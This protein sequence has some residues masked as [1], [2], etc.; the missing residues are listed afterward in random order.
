MGF[1]AFTRYIDIPQVV[2]YLF[3]IFFVGLIYYLRRE[4]KREGYPLESDRG[5]RVRV[6]GFPRVP[7]PKTFKLRGGGTYQAPPGNPESREIHAQAAQPWPGSPQQPSGDPMLDA[8]GP[9]SYAEREDKPDLTIDGEPMIVPLRVAAGYSVA[10]EDPDP[11]GMDVVAADGVSAG[12]VKDVWVD[13]AEPQIRFLEVALAAAAGRTV[14]L[15]IG[16]AR[17]NGRRRRVNVVSILARQFAHVPG[18]A[19]PDQVSLLEEDRIMGYYAGG[20]LYAT[21]SRFGPIV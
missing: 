12:T 19:N 15:P 17:I 2:L 9:A 16:F 13:R 7:A 18:I 1:G 11:R 3:W 10:E 21:P 14:L 8:V 4:D 6:E 20:H 5:G